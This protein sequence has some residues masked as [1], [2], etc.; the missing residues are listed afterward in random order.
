LSAFDYQVVLTTL[1]VF[2]VLIFLVDLVSAA[3]RQA[4]R[5]VL[6]TSVTHEREVPR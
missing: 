5:Y 1:I 3:A 2:V 4:F 6:A